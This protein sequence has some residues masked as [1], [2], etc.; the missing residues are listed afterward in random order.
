MIDG[1]NEMAGSLQKNRRPPL[2]NVNRRFVRIE[3]KFIDA[4]FIIEC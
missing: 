3:Q 1:E 2:K 4:Y